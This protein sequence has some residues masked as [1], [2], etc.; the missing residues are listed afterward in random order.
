MIRKAMPGLRTIFLS[1]LFCLLCTA[2]SIAGLKEQVFERILPNGLKVLLL[3]NHKAPVL[4]FQV[5]YRVGS[6]NEQWGRTGL[7]HMLE[8]MMF[9]G[10]KKFSAQ[11]FTRLV[12]ENGGNDNA[13]TSEDFTAYFENMSSE[14][15]QV[16][17]DIESDRMHNLVLRDEDFQTERMV[18]I[19]ERRM[20]TEDDPQGYLMEQVQAVAFQTSPYHWPTIGWQQDLERFTLDDLKAYYGTYYNPVNA[21]LVVVGDFRKEDLLPRIEKAFQ[22]I[23]KGVAPDQKRDIDQ[24]Q[25]GERRVYAKREAELPYLVMA[26]HVPNLRSPDGYVLEVLAALLS[27]GKSSRLYRSLVQERQLALSVD[28]DNSLLSKDPSLFTLSAQP[29]PD[30]DVVEV[31]KALDAE[32]E[33]LRKEPVDRNELEKAKNQLESAFVYSQASLFSQGMILAQYEI[34]LDWR[35]VDDYIPSIRKVTPE[36]IHRVVNLYLTADNRTVGR[37]IPLPPQEGKPAPK[38]FPAPGRMIR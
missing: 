30:K 33:R 9:K 32:I 8:H 25:T 14:R 22:V 1:I 36:D 27:S 31:E 13:F 3:E 7:S 34:A 21:I 12:A 38:E 11:E 26:Y 24:P 35:S 15:V 29:L 17:I 28:A 16:L 18:V 23:P 5:W 2:V 6:R 37:L 19:E 10:S 20:R 4:T